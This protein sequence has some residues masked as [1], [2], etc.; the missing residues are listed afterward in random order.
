MFLKVDFL[1]CI[2]LIHF[3]DF[4]LMASCTNHV[5]QALKK[6]SPKCW[7]RSLCIPH[8][9]LHFLYCQ[10]TQMQHIPNQSSLPTSSPHK[11]VPLLFL[12]PERHYRIATESVGSG[13][14]QPYMGLNP[15]SYY[16][17]ALESWGNYLTSLCL[18]FFH[19]EME[20]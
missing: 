6:K 11:S 19:C 15:G 20:K 12:I 8:R 10:A 17:Q 3:I 5:L 2:H 13:A 16:L 1:K 7:P 4:L 9:H 18:S 14:S